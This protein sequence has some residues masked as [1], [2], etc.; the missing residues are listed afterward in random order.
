MIA[1]VAQ[2]R[3]RR[4]YIEQRKEELRSERHIVDDVL[5]YDMDCKEECAQPRNAFALCNAADERMNSLS[6]AEK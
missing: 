5:V 2:V 1:Q 6:A 3:C 4:R